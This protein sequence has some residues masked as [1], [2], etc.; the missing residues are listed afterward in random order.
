MSMEIFVLSN[1]QLPSIT[2]R[3]DAIDAE[4]FRFRISSEIDSIAARLCSRLMGGDAE[5]ASIRVDFSLVYRSLPRARST[6]LV[7][8]RPGDILVDH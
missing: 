1:R 5:R 2:A 4:R 3:Q 6:C 7:R 8:R